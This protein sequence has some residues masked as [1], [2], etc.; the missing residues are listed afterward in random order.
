M[1]EK[2]FAYAFTRVMVTC[3]MPSECLSS[4]GKY[5]VQTEPDTTSIR[6]CHIDSKNSMFFKSFQRDFYTKKRKQG[7]YIIK[8]GAKYLKRVS[9]NV[10]FS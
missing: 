6:W 3:Y 2:R 5:T 1:I 7:D 9:S 4:S 8:L 10:D